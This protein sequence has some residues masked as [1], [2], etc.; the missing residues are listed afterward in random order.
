DLRDAKVA[1]RLRRLRHRRRGGL[2]PRL[3][4]R[5]H[6][7]DD[8]VDALCHGSSSSPLVGPR[9]RLV[10]GPPPHTP[11]T[12]AG[13]GGG[14]GGG[15]E[16]RGGGAGG[17]GRCASAI[18]EGCAVASSGPVPPTCWRPSSARSC[19]RPPTPARGGTSVRART[20]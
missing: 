11:P 17:G 9:D 6:Q 2:L 4:A 1:Q 3:R 19:R 8:L 10:P 13:G 15:G 12:A 14:G 20:C 7:L 18:R 16:P 5:P